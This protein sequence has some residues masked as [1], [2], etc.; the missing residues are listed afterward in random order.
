MLYVQH[1]SDPLFVVFI[2]CGHC[3]LGT[4]NSNKWLTLRA[5]VTTNALQGKLGKGDRTF[6]F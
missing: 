1:V 6:Q 4:N 3:V 2:S 5:L